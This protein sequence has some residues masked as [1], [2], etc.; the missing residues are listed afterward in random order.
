MNVFWRENQHVCKKQ[1]HQDIFYFKY[2]LQLK[3]ESSIENIVF[4]IE[5]VILSESEEKYAKITF[6][7]SF[8]WKHLN[9]GFCS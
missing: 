8:K 9:D 1:I 3:Y 6:C 7:N 4:L 2:H 5:Q